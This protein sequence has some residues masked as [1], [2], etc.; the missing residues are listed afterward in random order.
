[1][2]AVMNDETCVSQRSDFQDGDKFKIFTCCREVNKL[3]SLACWDQSK[4]WAK[5]MKAG[6]VVWRGWAGG[7]DACLCLSLHVRP[8]VCSIS[9]ESGEKASRLR[10]E[11]VANEAGAAGGIPEAAGRPLPHR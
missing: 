7:W 11:P 4:V 8:C 3:P 9:N 5:D 6:D 1:M 2:F 10:N